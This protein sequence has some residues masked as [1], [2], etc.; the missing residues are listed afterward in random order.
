MN[1]NSSSLREAEAELDAAL[2]AAEAVLSRIVECEPVLNSRTFVCDLPPEPTKKL[3]F[4]RER[5]EWRL[6]IQ[7]TQTRGRKLTL[8]TQ[9]S[10][11]PLSD[12]IRASQVLHDME[13]HVRDAVLT[14]GAEV[15]NASLR[16]RAFVEAV[17]QRLARESADTEEV[18][19]D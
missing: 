1:A 16:A 2:D 7:I 18:V 3:C 14:T 17:E 5:L 9:L 11:S 8:C 12:K 6:F 13:K 15:Q 19:G 4:R 10:R